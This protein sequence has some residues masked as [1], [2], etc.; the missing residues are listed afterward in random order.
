M[1][2]TGGWATRGRAFEWNKTELLML[3]LWEGIPSTEQ[4][5]SGLDSENALGE[6]NGQKEAEVAGMEG[7]TGTTQGPWRLCF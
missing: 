7:L 5:C 3:G 6:L 4:K 1:S 2:R